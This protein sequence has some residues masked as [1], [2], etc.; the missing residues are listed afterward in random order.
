MSFLESYSHRALVRRQLAEDEVWVGQCLPKMLPLL[1][2]QVCKDN[3][4]TVGVIIFNL[5]CRP[6]CC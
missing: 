1:V 3:M 2:S 4:L 5:K 6:M